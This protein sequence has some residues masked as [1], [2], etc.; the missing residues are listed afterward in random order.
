MS[1]S[2]FPHTHY[3]DTDFREIIHL[4]ETVKNDYRNT[5]DSI[6][7]LNNRLTEWEHDGDVKL[8]TLITSTR[9]NLQKEISDS[10][11][12]LDSKYN[13]VINN[14]NSRINERIEEIASR[15]EGMENNVNEKLSLIERELNSATESINSRLSNAISTIE[16]KYNQTLQR[17]TEEYEIN[18]IEMK[19]ELSEQIN[20]N[21]NELKDTQE[22]LINRKYNLFT[23]YADR[24]IL[25]AK[26]E[27]YN[28]VDPLF[29]R[30]TDVENWAKE[31]SVQK[32]LEN[33][34]YQFGFTA[35]EWRNYNN[36]T[37]RCW[38]ESGVTCLEWLLNGKNTFGYYDKIM[39]NPLTGA[40]DSVE[41]V[42]YCLISYLNVSALTAY[43]YDK[44]CLTAQ[45]FD[46]LHLT[47]LEF[48]RKG[49]EN[50]FK[51]DGA[52]QFTAI[53]D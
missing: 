34:Y 45:D 35:Y 21:Y 20:N 3:S 33:I 13:S 15:Y 23:R 39:I 36:V 11:S 32:N 25:N 27:L 14:L 4:Y 28:Y 26:N 19:H 29:E 48:D 51:Y 31:Y 5:L 53:C 30:V 47:A 18:L 42:V 1:Y 2:E 40:E 37:C 24:E 49:I 43:D 6:E 16:S 44:M 9:N 46:K 10:V 12:A 52:L 50:D 8:N 41:N 22:V 7:T 38:N 17:I